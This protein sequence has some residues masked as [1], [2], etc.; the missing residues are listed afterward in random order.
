MH[1][2]G[3][4]LVALALWPWPA[5][6][7]AAGPPV[8]PVVSPTPAPYGLAAPGAPVVITTVDR[9]TQV[10]H[11]NLM[12]IA[13]IQQDGMAYVSW[14]WQ[15]TPCGFASTCLKAGSFHV[16]HGSMY[17]NAQAD[18]RSRWIVWRG[19]PASS[20]VYVSVYTVA[21]PF[22]YT[23]KSPGTCTFLKAIEYRAR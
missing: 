19:A 16:I 23:A 21:P 20:C 17:T 15:R 1:R 5:F 18:E 9:C 6:A 7:A 13:R 10:L 4:L 12:C 11:D 8:M 14:T 2:A 3:F 22:F